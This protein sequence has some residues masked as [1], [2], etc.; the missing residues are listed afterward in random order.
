MSTCVDRAD[1]VVMS[2]FFSSQLLG[3]W[4]FWVEKLLVRCPLAA[5]WV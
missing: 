2:L 4:L 3:L 1:I 5:L